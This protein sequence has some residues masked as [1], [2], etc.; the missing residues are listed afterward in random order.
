MSAFLLDQYY[1]AFNRS[2]ADAML[3]LLTDDVLHEPSQVAVRS[4]KQAFA[5]F[6]AHKNRCY[7]GKISDPVFLVDED[8]RRGAA[9]FT[10]EGIYLESD[11]DLP[12]ASRQSYRLRVGAF[13]EF[14]SGRIARVSNH[15]NLADWVAQVS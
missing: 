8:I 4:G 10:L 6:L 2:D 11:R 12:P 1:R 14:R 13:F 5:D 9:E 7:R 15:N 3:A